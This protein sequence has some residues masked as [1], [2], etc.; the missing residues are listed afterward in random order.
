MARR[1]SLPLN[2][3]L[4]GQVAVL[5]GASRGIGHEPRA[6]AREGARAVA[7]SRSVPESERVAVAR[8]TLG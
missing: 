3:G 2:F 6:R 5:T 1:S 8:L 7:H 4:D